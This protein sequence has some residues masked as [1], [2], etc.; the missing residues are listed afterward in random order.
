MGLD[1][2]EVKTCMTRNHRQ[3]PGAG[4]LPGEMPAIS[5]GSECSSDWP[6]FNPGWPVAVAGLQLLL[7][8]GRVLGRAR[9]PGPAT[10]QPPTRLRLHSA[11]QGPLGKAQSSKAAFLGF[12]RREKRLDCSTL[13]QDMMSPSERGC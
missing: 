9:C 1:N 5:L 6:S 13:N 10:P 3:T 7:P 12:L 2:L 8:M 11:S 4:P